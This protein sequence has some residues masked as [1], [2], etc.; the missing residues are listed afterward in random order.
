MQ[1]VVSLTTNDQGSNSE[2]VVNAESWLEAL[3][4]GVMSINGTERSRQFA[5]AVEDEGSKVEIQELSDQWH[6]SVRALAARDQVPKGPKARATPREAPPWTAQPIPLVRRKPRALVPAPSETRSPRTLASPP[7]R[8]KAG[9]RDNSP[10]VAIKPARQVGI[11]PRSDQTLQGLASPPGG[12]P[13]MGSPSRRPA[14]EGT[15]PRSRTPWWQEAPARDPLPT[16]PEPRPAPSQGSPGAQEPGLPWDV[17]DPA[18]IETEFAP[19]GKYIPGTTEP[20]VTEAF[21]ELA[22]L[23]GAYGHDRQAAVERSLLYLLR[24]FDVSGGMVLEQDINDP[25]KVLMVRAA[26]GTA[27]VLA[28]QELP[29]DSGI[30]G[31]ALRQGAP[32]DD[33]RLDCPID[34]ER[35]DPLCEHQVPAGPILAVPM[36]GRTRQEGVIVL[37]RDA[38]AEPFTESQR[39]I[40]QYVAS[41]LGHYLS[42]VRFELEQIEREAAV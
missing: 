27:E 9:R 23:Y 19:D 24:S 11:Q 8:R 7:A 22:D 21:M 17:H 36:A 34:E 39:D 32:M 40:V 10:P 5:V 30:A 38:G 13:R 33:E 15:P 20:F 25:R 12:P 35:A 4:R 6:I 29:L 3:A 28:G 41:A 14:P 2:I 31:A 26:A 18:G 37:Y 16:G 1:Y 42:T